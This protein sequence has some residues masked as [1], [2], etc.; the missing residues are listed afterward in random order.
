M[1]SRQVYNPVDEPSTFQVL[2][3]YTKSPVFFAGLILF[4]GF[5]F[6]SD[7]SVFV[8]LMFPLDGQGDQ[9]LGRLPNSLLTIN[10]PF[11]LLRGVVMEQPVLSSDVPF[12]W[13]PHR[14]DVIMIQQILKRCYGIEPVILE[15]KQDIEEAKQVHLAARKSDTFA[16]V[17]PLL[18]E[19]LEVFTP[20][21]MGRAVCF[22][23]HPLDYD[24]HSSLPPKDSATNY[25]VRYILQLDKDASVGFKELGDTKQLV[26]DVCIVSVIDKAAESIKRAADY[27]GWMLEGSQEC[28]EEIVERETPKE[29]YLDHSTSEW[30]QFYRE[31]H[32]DC[33]VYEFAQQAWRAQMQTI[34]PLKLQVQ[35][36]DARNRNDE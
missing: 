4:M 2:L 26:R 12:F 21:H 6:W 30:Q 27:F 9:S 31:N 7:A 11:T 19:A 33:Q 24:F 15:T 28:V 14:S 17:S 29:R 10:Y 34:I 20:K 5:A 8:E 35:R 22:F 32:F 1:S 13:H 36:E 18:P 3:G 16:I 25:L 23:R